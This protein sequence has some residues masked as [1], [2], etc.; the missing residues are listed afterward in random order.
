ML[1]K[2]F[3]VCF[4]LILPNQILLPVEL[5]NR[6]DISQIRLTKIGGYGIIR[7]A[8]PNVPV[9]FHT[10][11]DIVRPSNSYSNEPIYPI[12]KGRVVSKR[13]DGAYANLIVEHEIDGVSV[14]TL[15]EHISGITVGINSIADPKTPIARFMNRVELDRYGW[16]FDHFHLEILKVKPVPLKPIDRFP[17]RFFKSYSLVCF[18]L[19]ELNKYYYDPFLFFKRYL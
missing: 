16:Q 10:G 5:S 7:K 4:L 13:N 18:S 2:Q 17:E 19:E 9:H 1:L 6:K 15:Y 14:W 12:A 11:I 3:V 8:R